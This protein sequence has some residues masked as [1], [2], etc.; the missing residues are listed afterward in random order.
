MDELNG[1]IRG[2]QTYK[3]IEPVVFVEGGARMDGHARPDGVLKAHPKGGAERKG[4]NIGDARQ[5]L[6]ACRCMCAR[7]A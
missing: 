3:E 6:H 7:H 4:L 1:W 5:N 2:P